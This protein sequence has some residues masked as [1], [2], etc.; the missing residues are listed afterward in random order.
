MRSHVERAR[1][2]PLDR[3]DRM[4]PEFVPSKMLPSSSNGIDARWARVLSIRNE[5]TDV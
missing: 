5:K 3:L 4:R 1:P 2:V